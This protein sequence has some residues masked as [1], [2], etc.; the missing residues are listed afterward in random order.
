MLYLLREILNFQES[1]VKSFETHFSVAEINPGIYFF[2]VVCLGS[3]RR[4]A[5]KRPVLPDCSTRQ[6]IL[7]KMLRVL[8]GSKVR[9]KRL[10]LRFLE[11]QDLS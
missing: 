3:T 11:I 7:K 10:D 2:S 4:G 6:K 8:Y 5:G 9:F 1:Q